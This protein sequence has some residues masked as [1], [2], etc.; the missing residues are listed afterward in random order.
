MRAATMK[1]LYSSPNRPGCKP[2]SWVNHRVRSTGS[3]EDMQ[4]FHHLKEWADPVPGSSGRRQG[5]SNRPLGPASPLSHPGAPEWASR[6]S[7]R[8]KEPGCTRAALRCSPRGEPCQKRYRRENVP[9]F[10]PK[11]RASMPRF[12]FGWR[13][14]S[15]P[16]KIPTGLGDLNSF[17]AGLAGK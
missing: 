7:S 16:K 17:N 10:S 9:E 15:T 13:F 6:G 2:N 3:N 11:R 8:L 4:L 14:Q 12:T 1:R 5:N